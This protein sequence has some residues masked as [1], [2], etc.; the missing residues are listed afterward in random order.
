MKDGRVAP[1]KSDFGLSGAVRHLAKYSPARFVLRSFR[2]IFTAPDI[3]TLNFAKDAKF[4]M[5]HPAFY[6]LHAGVEL[7]RPPCGLDTLSR[8]ASS[9]RIPPCVHT[10]FA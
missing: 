10:Q 9:G 6:S 5:G 8:P 3:P 4:R 1:V 2:I 7:A